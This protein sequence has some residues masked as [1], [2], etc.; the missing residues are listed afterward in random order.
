M[1][2]VCLFIY[3]YLFIEGKCITS[4]EIQISVTN[5]AENSKPEHDGHV[6]ASQSQVPINRFQTSF[7]EKA[8]TI[9]KIIQVSRVFSEFPKKWSAMRNKNGHYVY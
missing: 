7:S 1:L 6:G 8:K 3:L 4:S 5:D 9:R 2:F